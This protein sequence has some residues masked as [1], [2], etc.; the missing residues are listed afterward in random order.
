MIDYWLG[1][2]TKGPVSLEILDGDGHV[3][4][5]WSSEDVAKAP[6]AERY[7]A[8][9]WTRRPDVLST[10]AG[11]HRFVWDLH[12][13]RPDAIKYAYSIAAV[14]DRGTPIEPEG[15]FVLPG[16]YT[17]ALQAGG[18]R[19]M[20]QLAVLK[21]P[22]VMASP[23]E[24]KDSLDWSRKIEAA[25][26]D[27][28]DGYREQQALLKLLDSRFP[29]N[30][31]GVVAEIR[32]LVDRLR[33]KPAENH[34]TFETAANTLTSMEGALESVDAAPTQTQQQ[35]LAQ[36]L[37]KLDDAKSEWVAVKAGP[38]ADLNAALKRAK[39][40]TVVITDAERNSVEI[41]D[42]EQDLP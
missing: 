32:A 7:F 10:T 41:H 34:P 17:V 2:D 19:Y 11:M 23:S 30:G 20:T 31:G 29:K 37:T 13:D 9:S 25:L 33:E 35:F 26:A 3:V 42:P 24:L 21:D 38:L 8:K 18:T 5:H 27:A 12:Y 14:W 6:E 1:N 36:T 28:C 40:D 16:H 22:R 4:R 39:E 15:P